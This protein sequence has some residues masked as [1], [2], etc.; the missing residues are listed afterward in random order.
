MK[1]N[2]VGGAYSLDNIEIDCQTCIN[3]YAQAP[4]NG[5]G[6]SALIP[7]A[8]LVKKH[9][10]N[11]AI[12]GMQRL[13]NNWILVVSGTSAYRVKGTN[14]AL[15]GTVGASTHV[16]IADNGI[17]AV[18]ATG[19]KLYKVD[20]NTWAISQ[21]TAEGFTGCQYIQFIDGRFVFA[22]PDTGKYSWFG[23]YNLEFDA[24]NYATAEGSPDNIVR[25]AVVGSE[26]WALG[27][28]TTEVYYNTGNADL[29]FRRVGGAFVSVGCD[30]PQTVAK[31]GGSLV[32]IAKTE[33]GG[34]QICMTQGYQAQRISTH[35][36]EQALTDAN[37]KLATAFTYQQSGHGF[38]VLNLP[39]IN[40]TFVFDVMTALWHERAHMGST[41][42]ITRYRG[43][44]HAYDGTDNLIGDYENGN[45]YA[46][47]EDVFTDD[48]QAVYRER[49]L[50]YFPSEKKN[51]SY[52]RLELEMS[53]NA[54]LT[55]HS[56]DM[57]WSDDYARTWSTPM[58]QLLGAE[59]M[60]L[61]RVV[62]RRLGIGRQRTYKFTTT[63]NS[64]CAL[65]N[66]YLEV[67]GSDR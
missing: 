40:R 3:W 16:T 15:I 35:A 53:V 65:I 38:Y 37:V 22:V 48:G 6:Q 29:P 24:L 36:I 43:Q 63:A 54:S 58:P 51:V 45:I 12:K 64:R 26:M 61:K 25:L 8:G 57:A 4:E 34:R 21:V 62:W 50:P 41:G 33:A 42:A 46:L 14:S 18:I 67:Q 30:A 32:F 1:L 44:H 56:I 27:E 28:H 23:L 19:S 11:G 60:D 39:D 52:M 7:T 5:G 66:G 10:L 2:L 17:V 13:S 49:T 55:Q 31:M 9:T 20:L 47:R 59:G